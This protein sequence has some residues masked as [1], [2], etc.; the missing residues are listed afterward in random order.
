MKSKYKLSISVFLN[1]SSVRNRINLLYAHRSINIKMIIL[2]IT[3]GRLQQ[4]PTVFYLS[5][6]YPILYPATIEIMVKEQE[7]KDAQEHLVCLV[8]RRRASPL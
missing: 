6:L 2:R 1:K 4:S 7:K 5:I 8:S 3:V